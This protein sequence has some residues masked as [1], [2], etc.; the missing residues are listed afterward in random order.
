VTAA[1]PPPAA[2]PAGAARPSGAMRVKAVLRRDGPLAVDQL[3]RRL[4]RP[5]RPTPHEQ[6]IE[7]Q[8]DRNGADPRTFVTLAMR[9]LVVIVARGEVRDQVARDLVGADVRHVV[10]GPMERQGQMVAF[11]EDLLGRPPAE[12]DG[13][14]LWRDVDERGVAPPPP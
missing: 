6:L 2:L 4:L 14:L 9:P 13:V 8:Q 3:D 5:A 7:Q 10:V 1:V 12:V 11:F